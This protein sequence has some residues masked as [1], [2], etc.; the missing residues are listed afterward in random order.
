MVAYFQANTW[1]HVFP[2]HHVLTTILSVLVGLAVGTLYG[3][4]QGYIIA[5]LRVPAFI[6]TLGS[7]WILNG[8]I[9]IRT[10]GKTIPANQPLFSK[11]GQGYLS[12]D[13]LVGYWQDWSW[14][15]CSI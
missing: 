15:C 2:E 5:Y 14:F 13:W 12:P 1:N 9:L 10:A 6:V 8:L 11:I 4:V 7:M 3:V